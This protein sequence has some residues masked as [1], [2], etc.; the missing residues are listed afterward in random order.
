MG[1]QLLKNAIVPVEEIVHDFSVE[2]LKG[3]QSA[4]IIDN[5]AEVKRLQGKLKNAINARINGTGRA[6]AV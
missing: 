1:P 2:M 6:I 3:L 4:F 5:V